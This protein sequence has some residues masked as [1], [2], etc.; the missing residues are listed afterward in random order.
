MLEHV[1]ALELIAT[2]THNSA[3]SRM[4]H[5]VWLGVNIALSLSQRADDLTQVC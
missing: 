2:E 1:K 3:L 4:S 5:V